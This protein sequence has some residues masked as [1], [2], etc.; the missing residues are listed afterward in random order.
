ML[1]NI[2]FFE[3]SITNIKSY[4][5]NIVEHKVGIPVWMKLGD[6]NQF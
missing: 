2:M 4:T 6:W 5:I 1:L 3:K